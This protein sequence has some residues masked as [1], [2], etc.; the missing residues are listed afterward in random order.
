MSIG[1]KDMLILNVYEMEVKRLEQLQKANISKNH[2][3]LVFIP[4][5]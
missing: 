3:I 5:Y 1:E 2:N 4:V